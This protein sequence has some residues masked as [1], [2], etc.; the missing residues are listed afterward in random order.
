MAADFFLPHVAGLCIIL[1]HLMIKYKFH[2]L[3]ESIAFVLIGQLQ[4][5]CLS[6]LKAI[7]VDIRYCFCLNTKTCMLCVHGKLCVALC[8]LWPKVWWLEH[9]FS[10]PPL[11]YIAARAKGRHRCGL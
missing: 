7:V 4:C 1:V 11:L 5:K 2:F 3:P 9:G 8:Y 6:L 10:V